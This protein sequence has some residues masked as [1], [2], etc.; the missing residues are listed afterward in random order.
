MRAGE[1]RDVERVVGDDVHDVLGP[2][3]VGR[4]VLLAELVAAAHAGGT[5]HAVAL[6]GVGA[7]QL[8]VVADHLDA[9]A[10]EAGADDAEVL[11]GLH[12]D[13][14]D[15]GLRDHLDRHLDLLR[16]AGQEDR[17]AEHGDQAG[18]AE[19]DGGALLGRVVP[20]VGELIAE[21]GRVGGAGL[22]V[23]L[24]GRGS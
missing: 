14:D 3:G 17:A 15:L 11:A 12:R 9:A 2:H 5:A 13:R 18:D 4:E 16:A 21:G 19:P 22:H 24:D 20:P 1:G 6:G 23:H 8:D 10:L 7:Q